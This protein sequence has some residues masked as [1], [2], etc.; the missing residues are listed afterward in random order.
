MFPLPCNNRNRE[1]DRRW[2]LGFLILLIVLPGLILLPGCGKGGSG[3]EARDTDYE[4][5]VALTEALNRDFDSQQAVL[6][7]IE[8]TKSGR[9]PLNQALDDVVDQS[10]SLLEYITAISEPADP[11]D[12]DLAEARRLAEEYL[13]ERVHQLEAVFGA[14]SP[15]EFEALYNLDRQELDEQRQRIVDLL[16]KY[17]PGIRDL[18]DR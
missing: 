9:Y 6:G 15:Q 1:T 4:V 3:E 18:L 2:Y 5:R 10:L 16:L 12:S 8:S 7:L 17:D 11:Q 13:R 14:T